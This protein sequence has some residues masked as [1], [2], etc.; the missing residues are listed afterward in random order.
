MRGQGHTRDLPGREV[1]TKRDMS[2]VRVLYS[3]KT[4]SPRDWLATDVYKTCSGRVGRTAVV[5]CRLHT[6]G[7][8]ESSHSSSTF[9]SLKILAPG[10]S[11]QPGMIPKRA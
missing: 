9:R 11:E 3:T 2:F 1:I 10:D 4:P 7:E 5:V 8:R 6:E